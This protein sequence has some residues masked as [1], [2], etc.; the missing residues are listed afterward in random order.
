M[1]LSAALKVGSTPRR[2]LLHA[3]ATGRIALSGPVLQED[4]G[5]LARPKFRSTLSDE[6]REDTLNMLTVGAL[7]VEAQE[8]VVAC[9]DPKDDK[10]LELALAAGADV[11]VTGDADLLAL[12][13]WRGVRVLTPA[14][15]LAAFGPPR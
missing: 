4:Q 13:P 2:A 7:Q 11:I 8:P 14:G 9:R 5:V 15:F 6:M 12:D 10:Y 1:I 3:A